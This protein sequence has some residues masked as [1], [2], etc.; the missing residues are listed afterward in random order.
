MSIRNNLWVGKEANTRTGNRGTGV[1]T[2]SRT[3]RPKSRLSATRS[4]AR[5]SISPSIL[6]PRATSMSNSIQSLAVRKP[7]KVLTVAVSTTAQS[8]PRTLSTRSTTPS[9]ALLQAD[10]KRGISDQ[11]GTLLLFRLFTHDE[12]VWRCLPSRFGA[13]GTD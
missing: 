9:G 7:F 10:F 3:S 13:I 12:H 4:T 5:W 6:T 11:N 2:G 1:T 8:W